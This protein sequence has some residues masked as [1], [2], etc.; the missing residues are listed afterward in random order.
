MDKL[1]EKVAYLQTELDKL[2][3]AYDV[4]S[5]DDD[6][7]VAENTRLQKQLGQQ[8]LTIKRLLKE[9]RDVQN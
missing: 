2:R 6:S 8:G 9:L 1:E 3:R 5:T 4:L 7:L